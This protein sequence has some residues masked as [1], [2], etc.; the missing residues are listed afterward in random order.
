[1]VRRPYP[2][3][4]IADVLQKLEG[5]CYATSLDLNMGYYSVRLDPDSQKL[6]TIITPWGKYQYLWLTMGVNV[7]PDIFQEKMSDLILISLSKNILVLVLVGM[8]VFIL[9]FKIMRT[10]VKVLVFMFFFQFILYV[11][12]VVQKYTIIFSCRNLLYLLYQTCSFR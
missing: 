2:I 6:C 11:H 12:F 8:T 4:K 9:V 7:S 10:F 1:M 3:P 5:I